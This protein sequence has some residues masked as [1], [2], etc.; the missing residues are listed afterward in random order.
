MKDVIEFQDKEKLVVLSVGCYMEANPRKFLIFSKD[1]KLLG[2]IIKSF[3][4]T[5]QEVANNPIK[6]IKHEHICFCEKPDHPRYTRKML[7]PAMRI[8]M[9][10]EKG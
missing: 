4:S 7:A 3:V 5:K 1:S 8:A 6:S 2:K 9:S 10:L